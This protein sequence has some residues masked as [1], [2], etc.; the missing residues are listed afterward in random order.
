MGKTEK[1]KK[2][3]PTTLTDNS[4]FEKKWKKDWLF[5]EN[6]KKTIYNTVCVVW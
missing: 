2:S 3:A 1:I 5:F 6:E 4:V